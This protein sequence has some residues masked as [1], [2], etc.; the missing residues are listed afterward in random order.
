[1]K[2]PGSLNQLF[3]AEGVAAD[4]APTST[5]DRVDGSSDGLDSEYGPAPGPDSG[6]GLVVHVPVGP[7]AG[8]TASSPDASKIILATARDHAAAYRRMHAHITKSK[9]PPADAKPPMTAADKNAR[10]L[11][12]LITTEAGGEG[13]WQRRP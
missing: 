11:A 9:K 5:D 12:A 10:N 3:G 2:L 13:V 8:R 6:D 7:G 1:M 4:G